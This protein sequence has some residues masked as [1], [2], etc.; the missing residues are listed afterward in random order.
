MS[1]HLP[2]STS[3]DATRYA[4]IDRGTCAASAAEQWRA[5][6]V[7]WDQAPEIREQLETL[8]DVM[9]AAIGGDSA[10]LE[11]A[12]ELW[13]DAACQLPRALVDEAR[14]QYLRYAAE[15]TRRYKASELRDPMT[16]IV[17]LEMFDLLAR[18]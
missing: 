2:H 12:R 13:N 16:S 5:S 1:P 11:Q 3:H 18:D 15:V 8:D 7:H 9:F 14:E 6:E 10:A 4:E 17:A